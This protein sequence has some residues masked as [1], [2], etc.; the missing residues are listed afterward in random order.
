MTGNDLMASFATHEHWMR[1]AM[2]E[3]AKAAESF[4]DNVI[5]RGL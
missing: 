4:L 2:K 1:E 5:V 3:A